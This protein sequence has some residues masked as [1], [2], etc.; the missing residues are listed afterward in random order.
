VILEVGEIL[1]YPIRFKGDRQ[2]LVDSDINSY[3]LLYIDV[4]YGFALLYLALEEL[5]YEGEIGVME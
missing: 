2:S 5:E 3:G 4:N 1:I